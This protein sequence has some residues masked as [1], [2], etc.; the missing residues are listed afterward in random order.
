[1]VKYKRYEIKSSYDN[2]LQTKTYEDWSKYL[3]SKPHRLGVVAR[4]YTDNTLNFI[5]DGLR[6]IFYKENQVDQFK[7]SDSMVFEWDIETNNIKKIEF[8]EVP[9]ETG[10]NGSEITMAFKENYYQKYDIF[11]IDKTKQQCQV[12]SRPIRKRDDYWEIQVRLI[13]NDYDTTLDIDGCQVGDT[14]TFQSMAVP[15]LSEE[16]KLL[17]KLFIELL[18]SVKFA[19]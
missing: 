19:A 7:T 1:M 4:M 16:G 15:E 8:A 11:R 12:V 5:T 10:E 18:S 3:G 13:D 14:T 6:N 17:K 2:N 9:T